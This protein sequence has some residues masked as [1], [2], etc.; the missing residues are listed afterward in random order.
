MPVPTLILNWSI[1]HYFYLYFFIFI[2]QLWLTAE[3]T[4]QNIYSSDDEG[5]DLEA[6]RN[7]K[8]TKRTLADSDEEDKDEEDDKDSE[9]TGSE[10]SWIAQSSL[11]QFYS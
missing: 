8:V 10:D 5:S 11:W 3:K 1:N 6:Q 2:Y 7:R 9:N 4:K